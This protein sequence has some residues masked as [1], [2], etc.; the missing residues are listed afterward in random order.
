M[1]KK[2]KQIKEPCYREQ[3]KIFSTELWKKIIK[4][5]SDL[6]EMYNLTLLSIVNTLEK[7]SEND[8]ESD[9]THLWNDC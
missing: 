1:L 9:K 2:K 5:I 6:L 4:K 8:S 3:N 7:N